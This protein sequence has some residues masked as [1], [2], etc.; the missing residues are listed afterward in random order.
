[1]YVH[2]F[3]GVCVCD[4]I[5]TFKHGA[6]YTHTHTHTH[7]F[8]ITHSRLFQ[9]HVLIDMASGNLSTQDTLVDRVFTQV[10]R[11]YVNVC[12]CVCIHLCVCSPRHHAP[13]TLHIHTYTQ[14]FEHGMRLNDTEGLVQCAKGL[15]G[16]LDDADAVRAYIENK[17]NQVCV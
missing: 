1:V 5:Y 10:S 16:R 4:P 14:Y 15:G 13:P 3:A 12:V 6:A 2:V 9:S 17:E 11:G 7:S 8:V